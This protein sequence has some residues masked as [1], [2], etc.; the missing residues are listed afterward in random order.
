MQ[1]DVTFAYNI[2]DKVKIKNN[3]GLGDTI[4]ALM[5]EAG[6]EKD[7]TL[8][9]GVCWMDRKGGPQRRWWRESQLELLEG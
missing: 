4:D 9:Y 7:S 5:S 3:E 8:W 6:G 1:I 2:G